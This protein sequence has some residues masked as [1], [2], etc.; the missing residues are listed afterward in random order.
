MLLLVL[1]NQIL[2]LELQ[3]KPSQRKI[4]LVLKVN[5]KKHQIQEQMKRLEKKQ[6]PPVNQEKLRTKVQHLSVVQLMFVAEEYQKSLAT[7]VEALQVLLKT[8][9]NAAV[10][11]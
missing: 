11:N 3:Q 7:A 6:S 1:L 4:N 10:N 2:D 8:N 9:A 5:L